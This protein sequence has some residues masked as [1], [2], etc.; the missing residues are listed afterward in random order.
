MTGP[1]SPPDENEKTNAKVALNEWL[2]LCPVLID[3][4]KANWKGEG[5]FAQYSDEDECVHIHMLSGYGKAY[6]K[7]DSMWVHFPS[8]LEMEKLDPEY[9]YLSYGRVLT[10]WQSKALLREDLVGL[11]DIALRDF[12]AVSKKLEAANLALIKLDDIQNG[13]SEYE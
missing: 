9:K 12:V 4:I 11:L 8:S 7:G 5:V 2:E 10:G 3:H 6:R 13:Y 1:F